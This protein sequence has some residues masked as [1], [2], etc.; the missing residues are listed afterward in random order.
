MDLIILLVL[1]AIVGFVFKNFKSVVY[2][3]GI[4]EILF[5]LLTYIGTHIKIEEVNEIVVKYIPSSIIDILSKYS[6]GLLYDI[7]TWLLIVIFSLFEFYLIKTF[8]KKK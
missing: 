4:I 1:V 7:L 6:T 5:R 2:F 3:L 8:I